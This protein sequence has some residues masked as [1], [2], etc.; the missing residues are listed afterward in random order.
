MATF[1]TLLDK[2][3]RIAGLTIG[4][5]LELRQKGNNL[6]AVENAFGTWTDIGRS[7]PHFDHFYA[8]EGE[9]G[10]APLDACRLLSPAANQAIS[11]DTVTVLL[12][13]AGITQ[14]FGILGD[15]TTGIFNLRAKASGLGAKFLYWAHVAWERNSTGDRSLALYDTADAEL[16]RWTLTANAHGTSGD[17]AHNIT[18]WWGI[19]DYDGDNHYWKVW[20]NS[21]GDLDVTFWRIG[22]IR[23]H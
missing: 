12:D 14:D 16:V 1:G 20:Q 3:G 7:S 4:D 21:G 23:I 6:E 22:V 11:N 17:P 15:A 13:A 9:L 10:T 8:A 2:L 18:Y 19:T 5:R